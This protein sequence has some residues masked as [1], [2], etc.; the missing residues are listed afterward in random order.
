MGIERSHN[1]E[2][3]S[4]REENFNKNIFGPQ[5]KPKYGESK[6]IKN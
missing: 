6:P 3:I 1:S 5:K 2:I 4:L